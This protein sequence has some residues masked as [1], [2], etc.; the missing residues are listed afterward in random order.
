[1]AL[2]VSGCASNSGGATSDRVAIAPTTI[3]G[4]RAALAEQVDF[5]FEH[6]V[7]VVDGGDVT[8]IGPRDRLYSFDS[9]TK[10]ITGLVLARLAE[11]A[12]LE[13]STPVGS[14]LSA[15]ANAEIT[16]E[17]LAS[18]TA[19]LPRLAPNADSW[20]GFDPRNPYSGY[21]A[22][23]AESALRDVDRESESEYS[24]FGF[25]L[26]GLALERST[27][28]SLNELATELVF[29]PAGMTTA[30]IPQGPSVLED[31][32]RDGRSV[33]AWDEQLGGAGGAVGSIK[34]LAAYA[35]TML[36]PPAALE[37]A[38]VTAIEPKTSSGAGD[39]GL[40]W[41]TTRNFTWHNGGSDAY[42]SLVVLD[43]KTGRAAGFLAATG[44]LDSAAEDLVFRFLEA[45]GA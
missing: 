38:V 16:L 43:R 12:D 4:L 17:Q 20:P 19:G 18:H 40:G 5:A 33:P 39:T 22:A 23:M 1:M 2:L 28:R 21:T 10:T 34:D 8:T 29:V 24:N 35:L 11:S 27:G 3:E 7:F 30:S 36:Q 9:I 14:F 15:G 6:S 25:Q 13:L 44:D 26:L 41:I 32:V 42:S 45:E 31:G 37:R